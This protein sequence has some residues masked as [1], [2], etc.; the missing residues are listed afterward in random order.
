M[1]RRK[2]MMEDLDQD[3]RDHIEMETQENIERGMPAEEA[4][5]AALR[6]FGNVTRA[7]EETREVWSSIWL[8]Q[9]LQDIRFG[10]RTLGKNPGFTILAVLTVALGIGANTA[11]FSVMQGVLLAPLRFFQPDRLVT[12]WESN[13]RFPR[14]WVSY[15]N[16]LDRQRLTRSF[17]QMAALTWRGYDLTS[18]GPR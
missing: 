14:V 15:L 3:I 11:M 2:R 8:E 5:Y 1:R 18:L 16:F 6:K 13:P 10:A 12:V 9:F 7:K 17:E 4:R